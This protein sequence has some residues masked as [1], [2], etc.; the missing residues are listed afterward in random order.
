VRLR[1]V[2]AGGTLA[3]LLTA[4]ALPGAP[5]GCGPVSPGVPLPPGLGES[6]G[7]AVSR[8]HPGVFWTHGDGEESVLYAV[9]ASGALLGT[10]RLPVQLRDWEDVAIG[11]CGAGDCLY[12]ADSGNND[13]EGSGL[14]MLRVAEPDPRGDG[15]LADV[16]TVLYELPSGGRDIEAIFVLPGERVYFVSKGRSHP[17]T[18]Y[19]ADDPLTESAIIR[20]GEPDTVIPLLDVQRLSDG[21]RFTTRQV[22]GA[23]A[24]P[25]GELIAIRTYE[26]VTFYRPAGDTLAAIEGSTLNLR[27]LG[28][29]QGEGVGIGDD[30]LVALTSEA[31]PLRQEGSLALVRCRL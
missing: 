20:A 13:E 9:D 7:V 24:S 15:T 30:G 18:V 16:G 25:D 14:R 22:T 11:T 8:A 5:E 1:S 6:S 3:S 23:S 12:L 2:V 28:E 10:F 19:R 17:V 4:C 21:P 27:S 29:P 26:T 31:G